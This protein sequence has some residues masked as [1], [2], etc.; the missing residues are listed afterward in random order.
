[1]AIK[2]P[3][4]EKQSMKEIVVKTKAKSKVNEANQSYKWW[5]AQTDDELCAQLLSTT[6]YLKKTSQIRIRQASIYTRLFSGKPL[7]NALAN[8][9]TLDNSQQLPIGRPTAN[10]CYS[11]VDTLVS[12]ITQDRPKPT[13]LTDN[14]H[15]KERHLATQMN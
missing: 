4:E 11:N 3:F 7:Y 2:M 5:L 8:V 12:R 15:Y 9:G 10:V 14:G 13:F 1:M 6:A